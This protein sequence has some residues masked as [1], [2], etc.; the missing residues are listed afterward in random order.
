MLF[1]LCITSCKLLFKKTYFMR[2]KYIFIGMKRTFHAQGIYF[3]AH[4]IFDSYLL[5]ISLRI[6]SL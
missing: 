5:F 3:H 1:H 4:E 6:I 2:M